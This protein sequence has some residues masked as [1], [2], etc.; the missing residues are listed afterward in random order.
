M[1]QAPGLSCSP[2]SHRLKSI[3]SP[4][5]GGPSLPLPP[6]GFPRV[7]WLGGLGGWSSGF[8]GLWRGCRWGWLLHGLLS[9]MGDGAS[10]LAPRREDGSIRRP[11]RTR[12]L[13]LCF[14]GKAPPPHPQPRSR[15][16]RRGQ[17]G[18]SCGGPRLQ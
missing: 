2:P 11:L 12:E 4:P 5:G 7:S 16:N 10:D 13:A 18:R 15:A 17:Q 8:G 3:R 14:L 9:V 6:P 1:E